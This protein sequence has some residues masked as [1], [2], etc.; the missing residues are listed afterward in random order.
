MWGFN[1]FSST[2]VLLIISPSLSPKHLGLGL[3]KME[4]STTVVF[5]PLK[6]C[7]RVNCLKCERRKGMEIWRVTRRVEMSFSHG[8][9]KHFITDLLWLCISSDIINLT[10]CESKTLWKNRNTAVL[11]HSNQ[12]VAKCRCMLIRDQFSF[13]WKK[14]YEFSVAVCCC[15]HFFSCF[16]SFIIKGFPFSALCFTLSGNGGINWSA[17][18]SV[19]NYVLSFAHYFTHTHA[20]TLQKY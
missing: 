14:T 16:S 20:H 10:L 4:T 19:N 8:V 3:Q 12:F 17:E 13:W 1:A 9:M 7:S 18:I 15:L 11:K 6:G 2:F 5:F